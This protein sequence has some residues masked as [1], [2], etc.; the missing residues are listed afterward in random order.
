MA[1][2]RFTLILLPGTFAVCRL[3]GTA[4]LPEVTGTDFF[5]IT[6]TRD[7]VSLVCREDSV[8]AGSRAEPGW[9]CLRVADTLDFALV[10]VLAALLQPLAEVGVSVF[11]LS[12]FD[13]DYLLVREEALGAAV[14]ALW[15]AGH[16]VEVAAG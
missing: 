9:R 1:D 14:A 5:S 11:V 10:G 4:P 13:T 7:E 6:R 3:D 16:R 8:P 15:Q 12:T 2:D